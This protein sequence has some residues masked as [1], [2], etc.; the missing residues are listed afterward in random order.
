MLKKYLKYALMVVILLF[1]T[2]LL[3]GCGAETEEPKENTNEQAT[4]ETPESNVVEKDF[5]KVTLAAGW[6]VYEE[7]TTDTTIVITKADSD[8]FFKPEIKLTSGTLNTPKEEM[9]RWSG[10]YKDGKQVD[11]VT[12]NGI[13]YLVFRRDNSTGLKI[14]MFTSNGAVLNENEKGYVTVELSSIEIEDAKPI[15]ETIIIK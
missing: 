6:E 15:L 13:E 1:T 14:L 3:I 7:R 12:I 9:E 5:I 2:I 8:E 10:I 4:T 11:N